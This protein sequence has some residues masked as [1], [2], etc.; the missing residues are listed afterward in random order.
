MTQ[1]GRGVEDEGASSARAGVEHA[2]AVEKADGEQGA[3]K[4]ALGGKSRAGARLRGL[5]SGSGRRRKD[6]GQADF[7][8]Q[9]ECRRTPTTYEAPS[10]CPDRP[11]RNNNTKMSRWFYEILLASLALVK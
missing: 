1:A 10:S 11:S 4:A 3:A 5:E 2:T 8:M 7:F 9:P 6:L